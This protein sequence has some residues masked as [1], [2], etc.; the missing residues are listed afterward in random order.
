MT[1][2]MPADL[3]IDL[4]KVES[5]SKSEA[6]GF[7]QTAPSRIIDGGLN[8]L[9]GVVHWIWAILMLVIVSTVAMRYFIGGNTVWIEETQWHLYA[10]GFMLG[11]GA[12][13]THDS[14]IRVDVLSSRFNI[15]TRAW[16]ELMMILL[17]LLPLCWLMIHYGYQFTERAWRLNERSSNVGGLANRW[18]IKGVVVLAFVVIAVASISRLFRVTSVLFGLPRPRGGQ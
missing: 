9:F 6:L 7:P 4:E 13:I 8:L 10:V 5:A 17:I 15:K 2:K 12:A 11:I 1:P 3:R 18:A 16:I 14:H